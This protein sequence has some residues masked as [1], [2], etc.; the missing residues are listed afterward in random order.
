M[1]RR[2]ESMRA[3]KTSESARSLGRGSNSSHGV[4]RT[5]SSQGPNI[6]GAPTALRM[7]EVVR[8]ANRGRFESAPSLPAVDGSGHVRPQGSASDQSVTR[9]DL[10][11]SSRPGSSTS[12][13]PSETTGT[14][15][16]NPNKFRPSN[17]SE[18]IPRLPSKVTKDEIDHI[19][20]RMQQPAGPVKEFVPAIIESD[21]DDDQD[22]ETAVPSASTGGTGGGGT[23]GGGGAVKGRVGDLQSPSM[24]RSES[25]HVLIRTE[26]PQWKRVMKQEAAKAQQAAATAED[27]S[28]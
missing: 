28:K 8:K 20:E 3:I 17:S 11:A 16:S 2:G 27:N 13:V 4:A 9:S 6:T 25:G 12:E 21:E 19:T 7:S 1:H 18:R 23:G 24:D 14:T 26:T 22:E 10:Q 5:S 15:S